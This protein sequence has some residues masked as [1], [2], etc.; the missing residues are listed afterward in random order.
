[1]FLSITG[2]EKAGFPGVSHGLFERGEI[3]LVEFFYHSANEQLRGVLAQKRTE[4]YDISYSLLCT[5]LNQL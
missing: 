5:G 2:A 4:K 1:M 3:E